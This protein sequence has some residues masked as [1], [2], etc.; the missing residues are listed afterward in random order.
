[1]TDEDSPPTANIAPIDLTSESD[2]FSDFHLP[3]ILEEVKR[4]NPKRR[5][6]VLVNIINSSTN[7]DDF[8]QQLKE[9]DDEFFFTNL[10][11][12]KKCCPNKRIAAVVLA[13]V[14]KISATHTIT[15]DIVETVVQEVGRCTFSIGDLAGIP[16][17]TSRI[18]T[19]LSSTLISGEVLELA[20][21][22]DR[23]LPS[24]ILE[25]IKWILEGLWRPQLVV[26]VRLWLTK[27]P[28]AFGNDWAEVKAII[29]S[30]PK[31]RANLETV[32][33]SIDSAFGSNNS[34]TTTP[35]STEINTEQLLEEAISLRVRRQ[36]WGKALGSRTNT[37]HVNNSIARHTEE[38]TMK[39]TKLSLED[40]L[41]QAKDLAEGEAKSRWEGQSNSGKA[42]G[43]L[44]EEDHFNNSVA[45][46]A[47]ELT[48]K[49][50]KLSLEAALVKAT[51]LAEEETESRFEKQSKIGKANEGNI[52]VKTSPGERT[53]E[54]KHLS[55]RRKSYNQQKDTREKRKVSNSKRT[56]ENAPQL[57]CVVCD[58]MVGLFA[59][60]KRKNV[61]KDTAAMKHLQD[62]HPEYLD[63]LTK[64]N[65]YEFEFFEKK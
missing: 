11:T 1:M 52:F 46:H 55:E 24:S 7:L 57:K 15:V 17:I 35:P 62:K 21:K 48:R 47:E 37:E 31:S 5:L 45:R 61:K 22:L 9:D 14:L 26:M 44:T 54:Q 49:D 16:D 56:G 32:L 2:D 27:F 58:E 40:A 59:N 51:A 29:D 20:K 23:D 13:A 6:V 8:V 60:K 63:R 36:Q 25:T 39:D 43:L 34:K 64:N 41:V 65:D 4:N 28:D 53:A 3:S 38:L 10:E 30:L 42:T 50:T 19:K 18:N 12:L 33:T